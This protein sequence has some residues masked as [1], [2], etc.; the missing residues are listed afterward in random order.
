MA[1]MG[2]RAALL[3]LVVGVLAGGPLAAA[4]FD[5]EKHFKGKTISL[6][7]DFRAGGGTDIQ[8]RYFA[9]KFG[10]FVPGN[11]QIV[12][13]NLFPLPA[14]QNYVWKSKADGL[15]LGFLAA[16]SIG[17]ELT[18]PAA[19]FKSNEF[20][21]IGS[22]TSRDLI[23]VARDTVPYKT[24]KDAKGG[25][26]KITMGEAIGSPEDLTGKAMAA[27]LLAHWMDA[28]MKIVPVANAGTA[29]V[30][31][32]LERGDVNSWIAGAQWYA[33]TKL[34]P[35]WFKNGFV[36]VIADLGNP[37][38]KLGSNGES[39]LD[40]P[41]A[42]TWL[43]PEQKDIWEG[44]VLPEVLSGKTLIAPPSTP[45][46]IL[47][48]LRTS[49]V[50][51]VKDPEFAQ[52]LE[53]IQGEPINLLTGEQMQAQIERLHAAYKKHLPTYKKLQQEIYDRYVKGG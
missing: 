39:T 31:L 4:D 10:K 11:P 3:A 6:V 43:T 49:Y 15:T 44:I 7:L 18:D 16:P 2:L 50:A 42:M 33:L 12:V 1:K 36:K 13:R 48:V 20:K 38:V 41:N 47:K 5:A 30:L 9:S 21:N 8:A 17:L 25:A 24:L 46:H 27:A 19:E 52:G 23:L 53:K 28:P 14:G 22:H 29:D 51:A 34:R 26:T 45:D 35:G 37:D 32:M 40:M